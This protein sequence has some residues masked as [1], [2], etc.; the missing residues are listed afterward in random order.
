MYMIK[1]T[2]VKAERNT[3]FKRGI[4]RI[5]A[6]GRKMKDG[7]RNKN[8]GEGTMKIAAVVVV[9]ATLASG[10]WASGE[11]G[12]NNAPEE[13]NDTDLPGVV[14]NP[15]LELGIVADDSCEENH[16]EPNVQVIAATK[17]VMDPKGDALYEETVWADG[18]TAGTYMEE[19]IPGDDHYWTVSFEFEDVNDGEGNGIW[20]STSTD[21]LGGRTDRHEMEI[22]YNASD[23][24]I[25]NLSYEDNVL[26]MGKALKSGTLSVGE[27]I[28]APTGS[29]VE[30][31]GVDEEE[32]MNGEYNIAI[33]LK[34]E[35]DEPMF[36]P[37]VL[38][39]G[40]LIQVDLG[41]E[42]YWL[43]VNSATQ[44][45][46]PRARLVLLSEDLISLKDGDKVHG[47]EIHVSLDWNTSGEVPSLKGF[48]LYTC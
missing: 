20:E 40:D 23:W 24:V 32:N 46:G 18:N 22:G 25:V 38:S 35:N 36:M 13:E 37:I 30:L 29:R 10:C 34:D 17:S 27:Q 9:S 43:K 1:E 31:V 41:G 39:P 44:W 8:L 33:Q 19:G 3:V 12:G 15:G 26:E 21:G 6:A 48:E 7:L 4:Q 14:D 16:I 28:V 11:I 47:T 5:T 2:V 45:G 42:N